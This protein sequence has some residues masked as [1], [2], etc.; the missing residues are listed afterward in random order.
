MSKC[1]PGQKSYNKNPS[2][3]SGGSVNSFTLQANSFATSEENLKNRE[4]KK[5][6]K[7][8][9]LMQIFLI[10]HLRAFLLVNRENILISNVAFIKYCEQKMK[11][12][13]QNSISALKANNVYNLNI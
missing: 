9:F 1:Q 10:R 5:W 7:I 11:N 6:S 4:A 12:S 3:F 13:K 2:R 8:L